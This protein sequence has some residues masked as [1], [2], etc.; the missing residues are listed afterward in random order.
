MN[1]IQFHTSVI[2]WIAILFLFPS[3]ICS[4]SSL[5]LKQVLSKI[6]KA[7]DIYFIYENK[8]LEGIYIELETELFND[9]EADLA[10]IFENTPLS[11][12]KISTSTYA[13]LKKEIK[14]KIY[15]VIKDQNNVPLLGAYV[16]VK[17]I[18]VGTSNE[19]SGSYE[20]ELEPGQY[21]IE[22][23]YIG[24]KSTLLPVTV[25]NGVSKKVDFIL[26]DLPPLEQIV[27]VGSRLESASLLKTASAA[28]IVSA[29]RI[30]HSL[31]SDLGQLLHQS[32][33]SFHSTSQTI[34][35]GTDH[36]DPSTLRGLGSDQIL[37]LVNGKRRHHSSLVNV[38][39]TIGR[40]S[41]ST[42]LNAIPIAAI[43]RIEV[44]RDG[45]TAQYGSDAIAG[46]INIVL[47]KNASYLDLSTTGGVSQEGDGEAFYIAGNYGLGI[48]EKGG[49]LNIS[50]D[51]KRRAAI[52]RSGNYT[53]PIYGD[54]RDQDSNLVEEFFAQ[55]PFNDNRVMPVGQA[56]NLNSGIFFNTLLPLQ[57]GIQVYSFG[58]I[59]YRSGKSGAF[60]RFPY[61][62]PKQAGI[63]P[64]GFAPEIGTNIFDQS[65]TI[66]AEGKINKWKVDLSNTFGS[67][68]F[69]FNVNNS[70]NAS[71][72]LLSPSNTSAGGFT[73]FQNVINLDVNRRFKLPQPINVGF[74]AESRIE[75]YTQ[76]KGEE[77]S[78]KLYPES[79][80]NSLP[81]E[82]GFQAFY[83]FRPENE[84]DQ[85]RL[86]FGVYGNAEIEFTPSLLF[87]LAG[88]YE[89]YAD[90]GSNFSWRGYTRLNFKKYF[91]VRSTFN[92]G[93]RAPSLP[94][95]YFS[96]TIIQFISQGQEQVSS[97]VSHFNN[98]NPIT[99]QFGIDPLNAET[100]NNL[101][102][103]ISANLPSNFSFTMDLY[104]INIMD[105]I[106]T[107]GRFSS[108]DNIGFARIL[109][110]INVTKAQ[111]FTNAIDT[112]TKGLDL[113]AKY[114][115]GFYK[116]EL[117]FSLASNWTQTK[118]RED[119]EGNKIIK[120]SELLQ[121]FKDILFNREEVSRI[122]VAQPRSK[123]IF[124]TIYK[125][126]NLE[127]HLGFTRYGKVEYIHPE[128]GDPSA[129]VRNELNGKIETRDQVFSPKWVTDFNI[130][131]A[132]SNQFS[133]TIGGNNILNVYPDKHKHSANISNGIFVYSRRV[134]QF[135][136]RGAFWFGKMQVRL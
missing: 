77:A 57:S 95:V 8:L 7:N 65:L 105:R 11:F 134:S 125:H 47:K 13:I 99:S 30:P 28:D 46:V 130:K 17:G 121:D 36:I 120:T 107:S 104:Q 85:Y 55:V 29:T 43:D 119:D 111:F 39:G 1:K 72:G 91:T 14:S 33:P 123:L 102:I 2:F 60:F 25:E 131:Y 59:N 31:H 118:V 89:Y 112:K 115:I 90:F 116:S 122:E 27:V 52:N 45:A 19:V 63:H 37:V 67:N 83:G 49:F 58:G 61:Q 34:S 42:D 9:L 56:E 106:V 84:V 4:Q 69:S 79:N 50:L 78:W 128:D 97:F 20:L 26:E 87:G 110:P 54:E 113:A 135:G 103:G 38:N 21:N 86:N 117:L 53:G 70:N 114:K 109:E 15:G 23:S 75:N 133:F 12:K 129:W 71:L 93:F 127:A 76:K 108:D 80:P 94:Q 51:F 66:G 48:G 35:D 22:G 62:E 96:N 18:D 101:N 64:Y 5:P 92:T 82:A 100:S 32:I 3:V 98:S 132:L 81:K 6:E 16:I 68:S 24:Y 136:L 10:L 41:V 124:S 44:L 40:G 126:K 73:Y 74:G 88:R